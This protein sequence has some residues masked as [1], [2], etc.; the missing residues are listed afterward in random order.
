MALTL[1][2]GGC[3]KTYY[4]TME[5]MGFHKRDILVD[6]VE[7]A[8]DSQADAQK[9]FKSA[10]EQF[11]SVVQL[12]N[13]DLKK[14]YDKMESEY[15]RSQKA[16]EKVSKRIDDVE[17]V[18]DALFDEWQDELKLFKSAELR[19]SSKEQLRETKTHYQEMLA[20]MHAAEESMAPVLQT[21]HDNV[22][23]LKHNLN[24]QAIGSLGSE[25]SSL[26]TDIDELIE[27]MNAAIAESNAFLAKIGTR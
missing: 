6:R 19:R 3:S 22:L 18:A 26:K 23:F 16:A 4:S 1:L 17:S 21:F 27:K 13:T 10:L 14:A 15:N 5:K 11:G 7:N 8:R 20:S 2:I 25:F 24:A 9:K 12:R